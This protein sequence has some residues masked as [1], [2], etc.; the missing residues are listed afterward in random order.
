MSV[1]VLLLSAPPRPP[2]PRASD[3]SVLR[4]TSTASSGWQCSPPDLNRESEDMPER[5]S[6]NMPERMPKNN[7]IHARN[8]CQTEMSWWGPLEVKQY[9]FQHLGQ[10][11]QVDPV[12]SLEWPSGALNL[13]R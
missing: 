7:S 3:G 11:I 13:E 12:W 10:Q 9:N 2:Q 4:R 8:D 1:A 6:E 5:V